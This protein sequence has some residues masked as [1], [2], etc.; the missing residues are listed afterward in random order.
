VAVLVGPAG[1]GKSL[2]VASLARELT[3]RRPLPIVVRPGPELATLDEVIEATFARAALAYTG[4]PAAG[5][6]PLERWHATA[7]QLRLHNVLVAFLVD[8]AESLAE[9]YLPHL[10]EL[11]TTQPAREAT[12]VMLAGRPGLRE[13]VDGS[14]LFEFLGTHCTLAALGR[15]EIPAYVAHRFRVASG[16]RQPVFT[17]PALDFIAACT[18]GVPLVINKVADAALFSAFRAGEHVVRRDIVEAT[19]RDAFG[20]EPPQ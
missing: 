2:L 15:Q 11:L 3:Y 5:A 13:R 10:A 14:P 18:H 16:R 19:V 9:T 6:T 20:G 4:L 1:C 17:G 7:A 12:R 8:E